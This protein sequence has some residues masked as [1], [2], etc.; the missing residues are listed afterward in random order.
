MMGCYR[1]RPLEQFYFPGYV[2]EN[3]PF[4]RVGIKGDGFREQSLTFTEK[5]PISK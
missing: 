3:Q 2:G 4:G 5:S 1:E